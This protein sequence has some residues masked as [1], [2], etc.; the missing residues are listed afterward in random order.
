MKEDDMHKKYIYADSRERDIDVLHRGEQE[1]IGGIGNARHKAN[2][3]GAI[4]R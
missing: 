4:L 3:S 2:K 1:K